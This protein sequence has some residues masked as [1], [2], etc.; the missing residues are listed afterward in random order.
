MAAYT[1]TVFKLGC[2]LETS[3]ELWTQWMPEPKGF[4]PLV[5]GAGQTFHISSLL[6]PSFF[7]ALLGNQKA[8]ECSS[9]HSHS[10]ISLK[11]QS[12]SR[13]AALAKISVDSKLEQFLWEKG[14][15]K[16]LLTKFPTPRSL[17]FDLPPLRVDGNDG[18]VTPWKR[19]WWVLDGGWRPLGI[20]LCGTSLPSSDFK[21]ERLTFRGRNCQSYKM[22]VISLWLYCNNCVPS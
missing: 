2:T 5:C 11:T 7:R 9:N 17:H 14:P 13:P 6:S 16:F 8:S 1:A 15:E 22:Q 19:P 18:S 12:P 21:Q 4:W 3:Q 10:Q 20:C